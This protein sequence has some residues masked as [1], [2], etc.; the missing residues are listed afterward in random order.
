V[1]AGEARDRESQAQR[2]PGLGAVRAALGVVVEDGADDAGDL[3]Q[4]L[5]LAEGAV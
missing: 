1:G 5:E 4:G 2:S 3:T